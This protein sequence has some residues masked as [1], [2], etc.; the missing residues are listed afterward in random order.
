[1]SLNKNLIQI[2]MYQLE[3]LK[4]IIIYLIIK[5]KKKINLKK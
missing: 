2:H 4:N 1:M 3:N 5:L